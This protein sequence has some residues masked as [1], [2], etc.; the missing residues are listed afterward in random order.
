MAVTADQKA[1]RKEAYQEA[2]KDLREAHPEDWEKFYR[3]RLE[4]RSLPFRTRLTAEERAAKEYE[5]KRAKARAQVEALVAEF[6]LDDEDGDDM[7]ESQP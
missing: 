4:A 2:L 1:G 7:T 5:E 3:T 6:H